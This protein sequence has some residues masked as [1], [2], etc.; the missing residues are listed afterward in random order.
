MRDLDLMMGR[1]KTG[2]PPRLDGKSINF[3]VMVEQPGD[4][5]RP[6]FSFMGKTSDHPK[7]VSCFITRTNEKTH[8]LIRNSL[9]KSP[10]FNGVITG[11]G[12]RYCPS[13]EDK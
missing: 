6:V 3:D 11:K 7:Q 2:T 13:I 1:L 8:E 10:L 5:P 12:P 9:K 4:L